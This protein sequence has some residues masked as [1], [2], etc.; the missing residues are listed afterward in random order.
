MDDHRG[1]SYLSIVGMAHVWMT[2]MSVFCSKE[3]RESVCGCTTTMSGQ[4]KKEGLVCVF[5]M[6]MLMMSTNITLTPKARKQS[7]ANWSDNDRDQK[8]LHKPW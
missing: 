1:K 2:I 5:V 8:V 6:M 3:W 7:K 4:N